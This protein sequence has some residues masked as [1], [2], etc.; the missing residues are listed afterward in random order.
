MTA[1]AVGIPQ[2]VRFIVPDT[3]KASIRRRIQLLSAVCHAIRRVQLYRA[4]GGITEAC[5]S[6]PH[7]RSADARPHLS[8]RTSEEVLELGDGR[9][10]RARGGMRQRLAGRQRRKLELR[11]GKR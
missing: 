8:A 1:N 2:C 11:V 5:C 3:E 4:N 10:R 6:C 9:R 7:E